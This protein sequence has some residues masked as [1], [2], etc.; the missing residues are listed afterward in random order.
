MAEGP[1]AGVGAVAAG[2]LP[3]PE[4]DVDSLAA[5]DVDHQA[6]RQALVHQLRDVPGEVASS[7][8]PAGVDPTDA[9]RTAVDQAPSEA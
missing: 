8:G 2:T 7:E 4:D 9:A 1:A 3:L 6:D 5:A